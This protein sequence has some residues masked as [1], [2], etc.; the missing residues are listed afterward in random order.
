MTAV[1]AASQT[2]AAGQQPPV[3]WNAKPPW[4][5]QPELLFDQQRKAPFKVFDNL[6]HVGI[7]TSPNFLLVTNPPPFVAGPARLT[8]W[9]DA[10]I[11]LM[12]QKL[13]L[14]NDSARSATRE[15]PVS[16]GNP[17]SCETT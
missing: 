3:N 13:A 4:G 16:I 14:E 2:P 5:E 1:S 6:W 17:S 11:A 8:A 7:Q 10:I 12:N 9:F 15:R